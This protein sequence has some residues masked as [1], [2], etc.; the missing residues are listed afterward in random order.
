MH[1][2]VQ[3]HLQVLLHDGMD[4]LIHVP[5]LCQCHHL[6]AG[7]TCLQCLSCPRTANGG[8][9]MPVSILFLY[10]GFPEALWTHLIIDCDPEL[11]LGSLGMPV[12]CMS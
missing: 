9:G 6:V 3:P 10:Q 8:T 7:H 4:K 2:F 11:P 1:P 12:L 5:A